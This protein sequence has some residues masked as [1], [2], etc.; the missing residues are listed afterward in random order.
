M[1]PSDNAHGESNNDE[2]KKG[3][4]TFNS[5]HKY[6]DVITSP[7]FERIPGLF[8]GDTFQ[9]NCYRSRNEPEKAQNAYSGGCSAKSFVVVEQ[10][11]V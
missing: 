10:P 6:L 4:R 1:K 5:D 8:D 3:I 9:R 11:P 7:W 2:I